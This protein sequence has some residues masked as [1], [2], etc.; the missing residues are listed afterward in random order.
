MFS[1]ELRKIA[2]VVRGMQGY[3]L[4]EQLKRK[5]G[6]GFSVQPDMLDTND[7][8]FFLNVSYQGQRLGKAIV[9]RDDSRFIWN[10]PLRA[11]GNESKTCKDLS[12][13]SRK[14]KQTS[15]SH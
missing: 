10:H 3:E 9:D 6:S 7:E 8:T 15:R 13:L 11:G 14:I 12:D 1:S 5:L 2:H 4:V